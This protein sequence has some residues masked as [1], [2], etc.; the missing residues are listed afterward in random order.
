[1]R[2]QV[3]FQLK[4]ARLSGLRAE[5]LRGEGSGTRTN[6]PCRLIAEPRVLNVFGHRFVPALIVPALILKKTVSRLIVLGYLGRV[7]QQVV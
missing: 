6:L 4:K 3:K 7:A 5:G 1:M 2:S